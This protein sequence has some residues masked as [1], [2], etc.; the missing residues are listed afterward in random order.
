MA[1]EF[2][3]SKHY[4]GEVE[5]KFYPNSH[6]YQIVGRKDFLIG[7]TTATGMLDKSRPLMI[8]AGRL[9][10][11]FLIDSLK[12]GT[13]ITED[14]IDLAI[15]EP[16]KKKEEAASIGSLVHE[17]A[18]AYIKG[19]NPDVPTDENVKN[20]VLGFLRWVKEN[21]VK[22]IFS[23]KRVYSRKYDYVGTM[24]TAFT[25]G[26]EDHKIIH[27]GDFKTSSGVYLD[28]AFQLAGYQ[29]AETEEFGTKFGSKFVIKFDKETGEFKEKEFEV[30]EQA[31]HFQ[32]FLACLALKKLSK[33]WETKH[34]YY[35]KNK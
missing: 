34:G 8:W 11:Q 30:S 13:Q 28:H 4:N 16:N 17:W 15:A 27:P 9:I 14:L 5:I 20:G 18:E 22:F 3:I 21:D 7:T 25:M 33:V 29:E 10:R 23:E 32:G 24:D 31:D 6:R 1:T 19:D 2:E 26:K 35:A 12:S